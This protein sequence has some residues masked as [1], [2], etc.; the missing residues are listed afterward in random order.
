MQFKVVALA[1]LAGANLASA[2]L[3][4]PT[5]TEAILDGVCFDAFDCLLVCHSLVS[6]FTISR[7]TKITSPATGVPAATIL[8][9]T[10]GCLVFWGQQR[11]SI[12]AI[13]VANI[14]TEAV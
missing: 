4:S 13:S 8:E 7:L 9:T 5:R 12:H 10:L 2:E 11:S 1:V 3:S 14:P 6:V